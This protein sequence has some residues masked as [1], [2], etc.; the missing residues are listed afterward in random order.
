MIKTI[1][2]VRRTVFGTHSRVEVLQRATY[3][4]LPSYLQNC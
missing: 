3:T 4:A 2:L 1:S